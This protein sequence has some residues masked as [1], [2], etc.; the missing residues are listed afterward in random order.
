MH[1]PNKDIGG[2]QDTA[3][4]EEDTEDKMEDRQSATSGVEIARSEE[5]PQSCIAICK[6]L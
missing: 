2:R 1:G 6:G 4:Q 5:T 3:R